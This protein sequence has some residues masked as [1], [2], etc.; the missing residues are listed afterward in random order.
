MSAQFPYK[1]M[2][3]I[4]LAHA[5]LAMEADGVGHI[6]ISYTKTL[7]LDGSKVLDTEVAHLLTFHYLPS[8]TLYQIVMLPGSVTEILERKTFTRVVTQSRTR[9]SMIID[10]AWL[11]PKDH[12][13]LCI[14][15]I[16][17]GSTSY[18]KFHPLS[19]HVEMI[20]SLNRRIQNFRNNLN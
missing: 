8:L 7:A 18:W 13:K 10:Q 12:W 1:F 15:Q 20:T 2:C 16:Y 17:A 6:S 9:N 11:L 19:C 3:I 14:L 4:L 5:V